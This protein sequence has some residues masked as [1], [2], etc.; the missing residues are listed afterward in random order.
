MNET[1][2][3]DFIYM[4]KDRLYSLYSQAFEGVI[5]AFIESYSNSLQ[6]EEN[7]KNHIKGQTL[8]TQVAEAS[9]KTENKILYDHM[10]NLLERKLSNVTFN[11]NSNENISINDLKNKQ[12]IKVTGKAIIQDYDRLKLYSEKFNDLGKILA[13]STYSSLSKTDKKT[14]NI[15]NVN[16]LAKKLGLQVDKTLLDNIKT[17]TEFFN[18]DGYDVIISANN[19]AEIL[20]RGIVNKKYLRV[21]PDMLRTLYGDEPP[22][23]WT[24]VGMITYIPTNGINNYVLEESTN[25]NSSIS[26]AYQIMF[27]SYREIEKTFFEGKEIKKIHIAPIAIYTETQHTV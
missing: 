4:D 18:K 16:D 15:N 23:E 7:N 6:S 20:Y 22:M 24:L 5:E 25:N 17:L 26:D 10:Y 8:E 1:I 14:N 27:Q 11:I 9:T 21:H 2:I 19:S 3:R 12:L 13:Y